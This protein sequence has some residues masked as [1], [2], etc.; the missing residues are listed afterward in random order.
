MSIS[1]EDVA[2][3][4]RRLIKQP[5]EEW[6]YELEETLRGYSP[7]PDDAAIGRAIAERRREIINHIMPVLEA[8]RRHNHAAAIAAAA[9]KI[10]RKKDASHEARADARARLDGLQEA[11]RKTERVLERLRTVHPGALKELRFWE[12]LE[13]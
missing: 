6:F 1:E 7:K 13:T 9:L 8:E 3:A 11:A 2:A 5:E 4:I 12:V 10:M